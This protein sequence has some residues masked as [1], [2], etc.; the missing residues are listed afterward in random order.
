MSS[1]QNKDINSVIKH[2]NDLEQLNYIILDQIEKKKDKRIENAREALKIYYCLFRYKKYVQNN[3]HRQALEEKKNIYKLSN[4]YV[5]ENI[6]NMI[7]NLDIYVRLVFDRLLDGNVTEAVCNYKEYEQKVLHGY[8]IVY[9][10]GGAD[11]LDIIKC[12]YG[13][14]IEIIKYED[15][16]RIENTTI[17]LLQNSKKYNELLQQNVDS[18]YEIIEYRKV[19]DSIRGWAIGR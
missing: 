19:R 5:S 12:V 3:M 6:Q 9:D 17:C 8:N 18:N 2:I 14:P 11:L 7:N 4:Y 10:K 15:C 13:D 16:K 1:W